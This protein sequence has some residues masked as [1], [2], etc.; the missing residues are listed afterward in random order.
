MTTTAPRFSSAAKRLQPPERRAPAFLPIALICLGCTVSKA[1]DDVSRTA[2][3]AV[4][5]AGSLADASVAGETAGGLGLSEV[6]VSAR[7]RAE[8]AQDVPIPIGTVDGSSLEAAGQ[9]RLEDLNTRLASTNILFANPRQ[10]SIAV[11]GLGNNPANDALES[12]VGVYLDDV[13]LGRASMANA[14]LLDIDGRHY[15][16]APRGQAQWVRNVR[17]DGGRLAL[18]LGRH[19]GEW[20]AQELSDADKPPVLR[21]YLR[22]WKMEVG[23]FFDGVTAD[24]DQQ[25]LARIAPDQAS[26][27]T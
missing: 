23:V 17:A 2:P 25:D 1:E 4:A 7:R 16:V 8:R 10:T 11:R 12:S 26:P 19:R 21:A 20:T 27:N 24:S 3:V 18:L 13:Y 9:V 5:D 22:R 6:V 15:L 14:D